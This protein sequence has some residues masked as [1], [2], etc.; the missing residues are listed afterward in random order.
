MR[1]LL[2]LL[3]SAGAAFGQTVDP[4]IAW[5][6]QTAQKQLSAR[7]EKLRAVRNVTDARARQTLV[8]EQILKALGGL[9]DYTGPLNAQVTGTIRRSGYL[10]DKVIFESLPQ[11]QV[12][13]NLYLP[14]TPGKHPA[15]LFAL[16]HWDEGKPAAQ[17]IAA[18]LAMKGFVVLAFDPVGQGERV[19]AWTE[20][21]HGSVL[22]GSTEQHTTLGAQSL[23]LGQSF[24]RYRIW[25][26][27]RAL[28][29]LVSRPEVDSER[30][31]ASG[32]SGGG[33]VTT[34]IS[35][36][37]PRIKAAAPAC[38]INTFREVFAGP[39]G[40]AE[41][42]LPGFLEAGLDITDYIELF[43]PKPWLIGS[44]KEDF[45]PVAGAQHAFEEAQRWYGWFGADDRVKWVVGPGGHG[46][47]VEVREAIYAW[48]IRWLNNGSGSSKDEVVELLP[49]WQL[50][51]T[52]D[53]H[54]G[55]R[56][57]YEYLRDEYT[58]LRKPLSKEA[59]RTE[60][61]RIAAGPPP[62]GMD[63][64]PTPAFLFS[65]GGDQILI[66][67][68][69]KVVIFKSSVPLSFTGNWILA[70]RAL[71]IGDSL[72]GMRIR[73]IRAAI[74][75]LNAQGGP[76]EIAARGM[77]AVWAAAAAMIDPRIT[78][79]SLDRMPFNVR[80]A[81]DTPVLRNPLDGLLFPGFGL[82]WDWSDLTD[83]RTVVSD[84]VDWNGV[85]V[86]RVG[87]AQYH[88]FGDSDRPL[89]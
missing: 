19:Q 66:R 15:V 43:A 38:Y 25:D 36:L 40:D 6:N 63:F 88:V 23:F 10:I 61:A 49:E 28:D 46:T 65:G 5:M 57:L 81:F 47:P 67:S 21:L 72:P 18:N 68:G 35:A 73:G 74:D 2:L 53:G 8:R 1:N 34:Y 56:E 76:V 85:I 22:G 58:R 17:Q 7:E 4:L 70:I 54:V 64:V 82:H 69:E 89:F 11:Y 79:L 60:V 55:G 3:V 31:G 9:P 78:K 20:M 30:I 41:Q 59:L 24:A 48:M 75:S 44:T 50:W 51:A 62:P 71:M 77:P 12:T 27:K 45:F 26:A 52:P 86:P 16:G 42:S 39:T 29:Y 13:G 37:D 87:G 84:P 83:R 32:C 14:D 80:T 33:T